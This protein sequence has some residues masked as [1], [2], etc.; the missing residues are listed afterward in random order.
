MPPPYLGSTKPPPKKKKRPTLCRRVRCANRNT[1]A[2]IQSY[3]S[4]QP[5]KTKQMAGRNLPKQVGRFPKTFS[6]DCVK[7]RYYRTNTTSA[8]PKKQ[9]LHTKKPDSDNHHGSEILR[10]S[11]GC[12]LS[13][14]QHQPG[15]WPL[16]FT[17]CTRRPPSP[18]PFVA[19]V[20][21]C[22]SAA[23]RMIREYASFGRKSRT[24]RLTVHLQLDC[25]RRP[26]DIG[27]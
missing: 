4:K 9:A 3:C 15:N 21:R 6:V 2:I 5:N 8:K 14:I 12:L 16:L 22:P 13:N 24:H 7:A 17:Y 27:S 23:Y 18:C 1:R 20:G 11:S 25:P 19:P 26:L 10:R